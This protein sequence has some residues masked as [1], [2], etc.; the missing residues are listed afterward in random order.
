MMATAA[1]PR[2]AAWPAPPAARIITDGRNFENLSGDG[3]ILVTGGAGFIGSHVVD[4]LAAAGLRVA[5][6][7]RLRRD[8]RWRNLA[9]ARLHDLIRPE[10][11]ATG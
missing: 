3:L 8:G 7:D 9:A 10:A 2:Q 11:L 1:A 5:V 6:A 4:K